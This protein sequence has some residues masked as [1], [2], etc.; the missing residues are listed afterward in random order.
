MI[1]KELIRK[2]KETK[3]YGFFRSYP[4]LLSIPAALVAWWASVHILRW[5][6]GTSGT[7]D[8][9]VFQI[10]IFTVIQFFVYLSI[11]WL[12]K[13]LLFGTLRQY[14]KTDYKKEFKTLTSWQKIILSYAIFFALLYAL[15]W[16]SH[17][18]GA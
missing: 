4:E 11:A 15:V 8:A 2:F 5:F 18:L 9:G 10:I 7:F 3:V 16:L 13:K 1:M 14:L 17:T 6:D 12:A